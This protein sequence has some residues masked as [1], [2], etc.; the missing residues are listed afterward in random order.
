MEDLESKLRELRL[1]PPSSGLD[2]RVMAQKPQPSLSYPATP[3]RVPIWVAA[4][5][6]LVMGAA[7]FVAGLTWHGE[8]S[9]VR[10]PPLAPV[11]VYVIH[12][13]PSSGNP[14]DFTQPS[15]VLPTGN[16]ETKTYVQKGT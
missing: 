7:G 1:R 3:W 6:A 9:V 5:V 11:T 8:R 4:S 10:R 12:D 13:L 16:L 2:D 14:F 15:E